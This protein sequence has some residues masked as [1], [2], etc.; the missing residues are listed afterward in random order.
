MFDQLN[1]YAVLVL[2]TKVT[3]LSTQLDIDLDDL[4]DEI[5]NFW[6]STGI[7]VAKSFRCE[8]WKQM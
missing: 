6:Y 5:H 4:G 2:T 3:I 1:V 8:R 7:I